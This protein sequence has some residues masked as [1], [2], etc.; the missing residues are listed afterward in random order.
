M[1]WVRRSTGERPSPLR[2]CSW[3]YN[4][5]LNGSVPS[6]LAALTELA[7]LCVLPF[8][9]PAV[10]RAADEGLIGRLFSERAAC[11]GGFMSGAIERGRCG[12]RRAVAGLSQGTLA[13]DVTTEY[14]RGTPPM[15]TVRGYPLGH[16]IAVGAA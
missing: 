13:R 8:L 3:L 5:K 9:P 1:L 12:S 4:N 14:S 6:L 11:Q 2:V 15:G 10:A 16:I 7:F